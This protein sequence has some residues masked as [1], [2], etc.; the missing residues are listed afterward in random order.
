MAEK[1]LVTGQLAWRAFRLTEKAISMMQTGRIDDA[2]A[3]VENRDRLM[4]LLATRA[5]VTEADYALLKEAD[6]LNA[7]LLD[8]MLEARERLREEIGRTHQNATAHRAY[9]S[10]QVK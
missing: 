4:N 5:D 10:G 7:I 9:Q 2:V 1:P 3:L 8:L 6:K